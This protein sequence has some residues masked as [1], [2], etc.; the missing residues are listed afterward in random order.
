M[1]GG[2]SKGA[3][4]IGGLWGLIKN[5]P[6][7]SVQWDVVTGVSAGALNTAIVTGFEKGDE[8]AMVEYASNLF[9]NTGNDDAYQQWAWGGMVRALVDKSGLLD[10]SPEYDLVSRIVDELGTCKRKW[11]VSTVD[12]N[13]GSYH[14]LDS[15]LPRS[16]HARA[17]VASTL[18][19]AVFTPDKWDSRVLMDG[20][21]VWN[22]NL[23][24]AIHQCRDQVDTDSQITVDIV[25]C[26]YG[27]MD[28]SW[29]FQD[30]MLSNWMR[31]KQI[32]EFHSS[33]SDVAHFKMAFPDVNFRYFLAPTQALAGGLGILDF[34]NTTSTWPM[35]MIG[36]NDGENA[37]KAGEGFLF[38]KIDEWMNSQD[39]QTEFPKVGK[40]IHHHNQ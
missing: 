17:F 16:E 30:D 7:G 1:S 36:R 9:T 22:T 18:I 5:A 4:E 35:Q 21:A 3:Y 6:A 31:N 34:S 26:G 23:V 11:T 40:Y 32:N 24:S 38:S 14:L 15:T 25:V 2:G 13:D 19:P 33:I 28:S 12:T 8:E 20:G 10:N 37:V 29:E 39:L 27:G